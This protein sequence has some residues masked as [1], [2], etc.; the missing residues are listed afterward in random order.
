MEHERVGSSFADHA[1]RCEFDGVLGTSSKTSLLGAS[2]R[3]EY[4]ALMCAFV[5]CNITMLTLGA[6]SSTVFPEFAFAA[7]PIVPRNWGEF[8]S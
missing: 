5:G 2:A 8:Q 1:W 6:G 3:I 4:G 7:L